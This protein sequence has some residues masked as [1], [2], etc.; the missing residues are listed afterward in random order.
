MKRKK[1]PRNNKQQ[2]RDSKKPPD[3]PKR[4]KSSFIFFSM[5]K[6]KEIK[7][8]LAKGGGR[9]KA[10]NITSMVAEAWKS[11]EETE[12]EKFKDMARRDKER[13][14]NEKKSY[15]PPPGTSLV[16]KRKRDPGAPK[17]PMSAYLSYANKLRAKIK[18]ENPDRSNGEISKILSSMW[19]GLPDD[20]RKKYKGDEQELWKAYRKK[21]REWRKK[22][23]G[24]KKVKGADLF[25]ADKS[26][27]GKKSK[28]KRLEAIEQV[29][30][31]GSHNHVVMDNDSGVNVDEQLFSMGGVVGMIDSNHNTDEM[32]VA[33]S[34]LRGV[35]GG[36]QH[37]LGGG[38]GDG[39][40]IGVNAPPN[41]MNSMHVTT[42]GTP[43]ASL[44]A[45][46]TIGSGQIDM[47]GFAYNQYNHP[48]GENSHAMIMA[49]LRG[50]SHQYQQ[51]PGYMPLEQQPN[52]S[53]L[54]SLAGIQQND[55]ALSQQHRQQQ[56]LD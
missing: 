19:K 35:R 12:R 27:A 54:A 18:S 52:L 41:G 22:N 25:D 13:Y 21:I 1:K 45:G 44:G 28:Q 29:D 40:L 36:P 26:T 31:L 32:M 43:G 33:A 3:A 46:N 23:D 50:A 55:V 9:T 47:S 11:L 20:E 14:D 24:R 38:I 10:T 51:Y 42:N 30:F 15:V 16:S 39:A 56:Q 2:A 5:F 7:D 49:Q 8:S 37:H 17:R 4:F 6:H 53:Q 34:A 48:V